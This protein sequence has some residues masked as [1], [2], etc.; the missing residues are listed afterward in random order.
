MGAYTVAASS[1]FNGFT[2]RPMVY[3]SSVLEQPHG[4]HHHDSVE[5]CVDSWVH[6]SSSVCK[7]A[8]Q[9]LELFR[10]KQVL[11]E[12]EKEEESDLDMDLH[13]PPQSDIVAKKG[14][15]FEDTSRT[16]S[17]SSS[18]PCTSSFHHFFMGQKSAIP[19]VLR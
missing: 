7:V 6:L 5:E 12:K 17:Q 10:R 4:H 11:V 1:S 3:C 18:L 16:R 2:P 8:E 15:L 14:P 19:S 9:S 13:A